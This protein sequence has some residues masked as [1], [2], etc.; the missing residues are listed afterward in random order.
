MKCAL[1]ANGS[2]EDLHSIR[3][4]IRTYDQVIAVDG[5]VGHCYAMGVV[6]SLIVGDLDSA[7][8]DLL[9]L[10]PDVP[11]QR[12]PVD[13]DETDLEIAII[14]ALKRGALAVTVFGATGNRVDHT[15]GNLFLL[16]KY[17]EKVKLETETEMIYAI[18]KSPH[19]P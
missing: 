11:K 3:K 14:E 16:L 18:E 10:F 8:S 1:V 9:S 17:P 2:I 5:G 7:S 12:Y 19:D 6:P 4:L 13:K 15:L